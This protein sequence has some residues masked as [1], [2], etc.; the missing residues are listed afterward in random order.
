MVLTDMNKQALYFV[1]WRYHTEDREDPEYYQPELVA[2]EATL[3]RSEG[4]RLDEITQLVHRRVDPSKGTVP[5][6]YI[7]ISSVD[8][9]TGNVQYE[10][11]SPFDAPSRARLL[12]RSGDIIVSTVRPNRNAV[13]Y[14]SDELDGCVCS[15]G[16]AVFRSTRI[17]P[18]ALYGFFKSR[19]FVG[20]AVRRCSASMYPAVAEEELKS[21]LVPRAYLERAEE[22]VRQFEK[23]F[24]Y[25]RSFLAQLKLAVAQV[26][27]LLSSE[28]SESG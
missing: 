6:R 28:D 15:T 12:V 4:V 27:A 16:F 23:A 22:I 20:Q 21:V 8:T 3:A 13:A 11:L 17:H 18:L 26:Q 19:C 25:R 1:T 5:I 2:L 14:I 10:E 9:L 24:D 7:D